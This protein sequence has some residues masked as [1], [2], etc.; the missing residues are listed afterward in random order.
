MLFPRI[1]PI[2]DKN[3]MPPLRCQHCGA[4]LETSKTPMFVSFPI[5]TVFDCPR[6]G[7]EH[8]MLADHVL[9]TTKEYYNRI[10]A[11]YA[12]V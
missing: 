5:Q 1:S 11:F 9:C 10:H 4:I 7:E 8:Y 6:C 3:Y 2:K 12:P